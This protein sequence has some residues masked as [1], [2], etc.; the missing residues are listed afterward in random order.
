[1]AYNHSPQYAPLQDP[2]IELGVRALLG[3]AGQWLGIRTS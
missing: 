3:A 1:V 2:T